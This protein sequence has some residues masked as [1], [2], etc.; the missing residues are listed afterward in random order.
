MNP[1]KRQ[2]H[3]GKH[4]GHVHY[5]RPNVIVNYHAGGLHVHSLQNGH[6]ICHLS[7][8]EESLYVDLQRDGVLDSIQVVTNGKNLVLDPTTG[9]YADPWVASLAKRVNELEEKNKN[10]AERAQDAKRSFHRSTRLC[11]ALALSG[12]PA[13]EELFSTPLCGTS[14]NK[15]NANGDNNMEHPWTPVHAAPPLVVESMYQQHRHREKDVIFAMSNGVVSRVRGGTGRRQWK[16]N[17][18]TAENFPTWGRWESTH[19]VS[20]T[21]LQVDD[22]EVAPSARPLLLV[23]ESSMAVLSATSASV[24]ASANVPQR[25]LTRPVLADVS[26]DGVTDVM[27]ITADAVWGYQV[28][29]RTGASIFFRILVGLLMMGIL[30]ALLR[31]RY[32]GTSI[33]DRYKRSTDA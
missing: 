12:M 9:D 33:R 2:R 16:L 13:R 23:G 29:V 10:A 5:G 19:T 1:R 27:V 24:L 32:G 25:S 14:G 30:L 11:H 22:Y 21:R 8:L 7:M 6:P 26:G 15:L 4:D 31:N 28:L 18:K 17:G 20:F 3:F